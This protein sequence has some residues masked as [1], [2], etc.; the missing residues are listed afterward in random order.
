MHVSLTKQQGCAAHT[1]PAHT[2]PHTTITASPP[3]PFQAVAK[4]T[5]SAS[6]PMAVV[7]APGGVVAA[8]VAAVFIAV[9]TATVSL[10]PIFS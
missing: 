1:Q 6:T 7:G 3:Q 2:T 9:A 4:V 5:P 8:P 10:L